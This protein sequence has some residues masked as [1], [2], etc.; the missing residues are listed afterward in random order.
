[1]YS[2]RGSIHSLSP[3]RMRPNSTQQPTVRAITQPRDQAT[4]RAARG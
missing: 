3:C 2:P 4:P 1:M